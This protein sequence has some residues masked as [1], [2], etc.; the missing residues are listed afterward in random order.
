M[1]KISKEALNDRCFF[2][3]LTYYVHFKYKYFVLVT[4][5][6][7]LFS[8]PTFHPLIRLRRCHFCQDHL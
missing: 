6:K 3:L 2:L 5:F 4:I 1:S 8:N 7:T